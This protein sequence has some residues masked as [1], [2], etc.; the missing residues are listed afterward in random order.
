M[1]CCSR[2]LL[3]HPDTHSNITNTGTALE[4][5]FGI[6]QVAELDVELE[7]IIFKSRKMTL[8][9]NMTDKEDASAILNDVKQETRRR[10]ESIQKIEG[11]LEGLN[12]A[13]CEGQETQI[14]QAIQ[15]LTLIAESKADNEEHAPVL[16]RRL[17]R[18][19]SVDKSPRDRRYRRS[20]HDKRFE[21]L[22]KIEEETTLAEEN[23]GTD[24]PDVIPEISSVA[25][26][27]K[28]RRLSQEIASTFSTWCSSAKRENFNNISH[29][30]QHFVVRSTRKTAHFLSLIALSLPI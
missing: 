23:D 18:G 13:L 14:S 1:L 9:G 6:D 5:T 20:S 8:V 11:A 29:F 30:Q 24:S 12:S 21:G 25:K 22:A 16:R 3:S 27:V 15:R 7:H 19:I 26:Q 17:K 10:R 28:H 4:R 2:I